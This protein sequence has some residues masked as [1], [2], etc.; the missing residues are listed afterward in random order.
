MKQQATAARQNPGALVR[1]TASARIQRQCACGQHASGGECAACKKRKATLQ[2]EPAGVSSTAVADGG[3]GEALRSPGRPLDRETRSLMES[4]FQHDFSAVRVHT[5]VRAAQSSAA[6]GA[7][8]WALGNDLVFAS[9]HYDP[10]TP[11]GQ[12][13]LAHELTHVIQQRH[14]PAAD[15][16]TELEVSEPGDAAER[17]A[18]SVADEVSAGK[19]ASVEERAGETTIHRDLGDTAR[20]VGIGLGIGGGLVLVGLGIAWLA[21]AFDGAKKSGAEEE[22][23]TNIDKPPHCG[24][25][26]LKKLKP[27]LA[28]AITWVKAA[29]AKVQAFLA[30]PASPANAYVKQ[31]LAAKDRFSSDTPETAGVVQ[32][33][34]SQI[35]RLLTSQNLTYECHTAKEDNLCG[36]GAAYVKR[37]AQTVVLCGKL[38]K[39]GM[40]IVRDLIHEFSHAVTG[41]A[42][43][44]DRAYEGERVLSRLTTDEALTN[45]ESHAEFIQDLAENRPAATTPAPADQIICEDA[46]KELVADALARAQR[47]NT[48]AWNVAADV[49]S[50]KRM[51]ALRNQFLPAAAGPNPDPAAD[52]AYIA[53]LYEKTNLALYSPVGFVCD[54]P[55]TQCPATGSLVTVTPRDPKLHV[56]PAWAGKSPDDRIVDVLATLYGTLGGEARADWQMGLA[57]ITQ[58]IT[59]QSFSPPAHGEVTGNPAWTKDLISFTFNLGM[60]IPGAKPLYTESGTIHSRLSKDVPVYAGPPCKPV[61]LPFSFHG[62]FFV[63]TSGVRRPGPFSPPLLSMTYSFDGDAG[64]EPANSGHREDANPQYLGD[65]YALK[66]PLQDPIN[67]SFQHNGTFDVEI[68]MQDPDSNTTREFSDRITV[69][70]DVPCGLKGGEQLG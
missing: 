65:G 41:G 3:V 8:A 39:P 31:R 46:S 62:T 38:F 4:R 50:N 37:S 18:Q 30:N 5:D 24:E 2:R 57:K 51:I 22:D 35:L 69:Q 32:R 9:G 48:N 59:T 58:A 68:R 28:K 43:V 61:I 45:A 70:A 25:R 15:P 17:E 56:C 67:L 53:K 23:A 13:L 20:D 33:V 64:K 44:A 7:N 34:I 6:L 21:G 54:P 10:Q 14:A 66:T 49:D 27:A 12:H 42:E 1:E 63:D 40:N 52:V 29:L 47:W 26:Q 19:R 60:R 36:L 55:G 11:R 16:Q